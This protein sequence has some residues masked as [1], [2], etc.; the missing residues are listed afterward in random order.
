MFSAPGISQIG[1]E[2]GVEEQDEVNVDEE[3]EI[4]DEDVE[5]ADEVDED[6]DDDED[7]VDEDCA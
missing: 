4:A 5:I 2:E 1:G 6:D 7:E 3:V